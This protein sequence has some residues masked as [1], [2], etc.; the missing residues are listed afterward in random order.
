MISILTF[1]SL[2][3][4]ALTPADKINKRISSLQVY[5]IDFNVSLYMWFQMTSRLWILW[6]SL[7]CLE[8][9]SLSSGQLCHPDGPESCGFQYRDSDG[10][11]KSTWCSWVSNDWNSYFDSIDNTTRFVGIDNKTDSGTLTSRTSCETGGYPHCLGFIYGFFNSDTFSLKVFLNRTDTGRRV[12]LWSL[13][14]T[15][16]ERRWFNARVPIESSDNYF[17]CGVRRCQTAWRSFTRR[18][19]CAPRQYHLFWWPM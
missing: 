16:L 7:V 2:F 15:P 8:L 18:L 12:L 9:S 6:T 1:L 10:T 5:I 13:S 11:D 4:D 19:L 14:A 17:H 3:L